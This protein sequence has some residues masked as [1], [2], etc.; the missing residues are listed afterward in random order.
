MHNTDPL[1]TPA[2]AMCPNTP[3]AWQRSLEVHV[4]SAS[5]RCHRPRSLPKPLSPQVLWT[6]KTDKSFPSGCSTKSLLLL[7]TDIS[8]RP[9]R[10]EVHVS[11]RSV[12]LVAGV[13]RVTAAGASGKQITRP[14]PKGHK[15]TLQKQFL[16]VVTGHL[17]GGEHN[18][19]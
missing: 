2:G 6:D 15:V 18:D 8:G 4:R 14:S 1:G 9:V 11:K 3:Q 19:S 5:H 13:K 17:L 16:Q 12:V 7:L 10:D